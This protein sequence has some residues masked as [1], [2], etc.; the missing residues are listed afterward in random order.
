MSCGVGHRHGLDLVWLWHRVAA[1]APIRPL[2]WEPPYA[3]CSA[4]KKRKKLGK[5]FTAGWYSMPWLRFL[6]CLAFCFP[7]SCNLFSFTFAKFSVCLPQIY[8]QTHCPNRLLENSITPIHLS[9][10]VLSPGIPYP[11]P[12]WTCC[13]LGLLLSYQPGIL[14]STGLSWDWEK[15]LGQRGKWWKLIKWKLLKWNQEEGEAFTQETQCQYRHT[16]EILWV[17]FQ[18]TLIKL[19]SQ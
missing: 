16:L 5:C 15:D 14:E 18:T 17:W 7:W 19:I 9:F 8:P 11:A 2:A 10:C 1:I 4:L 12:V 6:A 3:V 13:S